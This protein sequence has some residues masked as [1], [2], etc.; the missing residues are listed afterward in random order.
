[1]RK[2]AKSL[3]IMVLFSMVFVS[4]GKYEEGPAISL[5]SKKARVANTWIVEYAKDIPD[6]VEITSDYNGD[7]FTFEKDGNYL[8]NGTKEGTW[9]FNSGKE[10]I[11][12]TEP[13]GS[14][15]EYKIIRL[16]E[17]DMRLEITGEEII[18]FIPL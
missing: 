3:I 2:E 14:T 8:E 5:K 13:D 12:I 6:D 11:I 9:E 1:M 18:H 17:K 7:R 15:D 16:K 4:C 10:F